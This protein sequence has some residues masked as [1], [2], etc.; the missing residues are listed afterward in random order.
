[1]KVKV[2]IAGILRELAGQ[3]E[4]D[5]EC[6]E[7]ISISELQNILVQRFGNKIVGKTL[8]YQWLHHGADYIVIA[9]NH[10]VI[11]SEKFHQITLKS[12]DVVSLLPVISGG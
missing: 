6:S 2:E 5:V 4:V 9:L 8:E 12:G 10:E 3:G 1:M 7:N 11:Q